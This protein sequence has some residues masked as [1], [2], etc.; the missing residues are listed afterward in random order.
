MPSKPNKPDPANPKDIIGSTKLPLHLW[1][2]T[3]TA[4]GC[5]GFLDG[6]LKY[7]RSNFRATPV[8]ASI[9]VDAA[10]RHLDAWFEGEATAP[11]TGIP[12]LGN[13]LASIAILVDAHAAGTLVD[14]R[15]FK[16][17]GYRKLIEE[18]TPLVK[19]IEAV[20]AA[21]APRHYTAADNVV[22]LAAVEK[23]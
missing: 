14:D 17:E 18:L 4:I 12:H 15:Q 9:Y 10:K 1:P 7:G 2:A 13:A 23:K 5:L 11:D 16:G 20:H 6:K 21:H 19:H 22:P 8:R 3:A